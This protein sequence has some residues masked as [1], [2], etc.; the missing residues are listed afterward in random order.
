[1]ARPRHRLGN[2]PAETT[3][4]VGR[5]RELAEIRKK[6]STSRLISLVGPGGVGKTRLALRATADLARG[7]ADG[8]W[9]VE[10]AE[11]RDGALVA[12]AVLAALD[13]RDQAALTPMQ[14]LV[15]QLEDK[16]VLLVLDNCEHLIDAVARLVVGILRAAPKLRVVTTSREPLEVP[17]EQTVPVPPLDV[18]RENGSAS[19]AQLQQNEAVM[20][21][22]E[23]AAAAGHFELS[24]AN[25]VAV[26][27]LCR[28]LDGLPLAIELAAVRTRV[29]TV[30]QILG[31]LDDRFA[32]LTGGDRVALPR[33]QTLRGA[34]DWS[35]ELLTSA[36]QTVLRRLGA[37]AGRFTLE[38][39]GGV[40]AFDD[41]PA[42]EVLD[43]VSSLLDKSLVIKDEVGGIAC[44]RL[45]ETMREYAALKTHEADEEDL[46]A[47]RYIDYYR[48]TCLSAAPG[49]RFRL[50]DWLAWAELELDNIRAVLQ[51]CVIRHD[52][53]R[54]L[55]VAAWM[56]FSLATNA[57]SERSRWLDQ[58]LVSDDASP[59]TLV[60]AYYLR[61]WLSVLQADPAAARPW[62][63]RAVAL[64]RGSSQLP[65]LVEALSMSANAEDMLGNP[66]GAQQFLDEAGAIAADADD[67]LATIELIQA[68]TVHAFFEGDMQAV[69]ARSSV[70]ACLS[71]DAGDPLVLGSMLR[72]LA[73]VALLEGDLGAATA[74]LR[75]ALHVARQI[76]DRFTQYYLLSAYAYHAAQSGLPRCA[77]QLF[78][79][80]ASVAA[81][82]G[83]DDRGPHAPLLAE[84]R[85]SATRALGEAKFG[86]EFETGK[87]LTRQAAMR[88]AL[89]EPEDGKV[90]AS[91]R[92]ETGPVAKRA[93]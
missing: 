48:T 58:L 70:G 38:D 18:P 45:H 15:S 64:A 65:Q 2:V 84:A 49:A 5:R 55:D 1:M 22:A 90:V 17:G 67:Y 87:R 20:L 8:A 83:A 76:D 4:F 82:A 85:E 52:S 46:L 77:A 60:S 42:S 80:A 71:R 25:R 59:R 69:T 21:F 37:F 56:R 36:E 28:R 16:Q 43:I 23:R 40:C 29:L 32:L 41:V 39:V 24:D 50:A 51:G 57:A 91:H 89:C 93:V 26:V 31:R 34:I 47:D 63:A 7:F 3:S 13:L 88:L 53:V 62:L 27:R 9:L 75:D 72:S 79:A 30:E 86:A 54:G 14:I 44:Y 68:Q 61:G 78:G 6:L 92:A 74:R 11:I 10:L 73:T 66:A 33:H 81:G 19:V 35:Y 12:D